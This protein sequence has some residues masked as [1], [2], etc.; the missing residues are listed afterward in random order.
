MNTRASRSIH[1]EVCSH[2][3]DVPLTRR[4]RLTSVPPPLE[5][6]NLPSKSSPPTDGA[7]MT[8][9]AQDVQ[10]GLLGVSR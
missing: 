7:Q 2:S 1:R 4:A 6:A 3:V 5:V 10:V 8:D 9:Y